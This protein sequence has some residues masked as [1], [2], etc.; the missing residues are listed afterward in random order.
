MKEL[1]V[2]CEGQTEQAFCARV[3]QPHFF[4]NHDGLVH[5]IR[6][7]H[8]RKKGVVHRGG[9]NKYQIIKD[10]MIRTF[11]ANRRSSVLFTSL[12]DLYAL[13]NDFPGMADNTRNPDYPR[14]YVVAL[15]GTL[16]DDI[17]EPRFVSHLQLHEFET[18]IFAEP[19]SLL[20]SY[21]NVDA[22]VRELQR[23]AIEFKDIEKINGT[24]TG[25]P[26]K[27]IIEQIPRYEHDKT[28]VGPDVTA[29][30][31]MEKMMSACAHFRDWIE[32]VAQ[33][34]ESFDG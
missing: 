8:K 1:Y 20:L 28:T 12:I 2:F 31:G 14:P 13:P 17:A 16:A 5:P 34:L 3:L 7:A 33:R 23:I 18:L 4:P 29:C 9:V 25:A 27:R 11:R 21:D 19:E 10:D 26:S 32:I 6:I 22:E 30:I 24:Q 15:E